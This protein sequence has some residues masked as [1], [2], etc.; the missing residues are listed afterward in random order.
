[1]SSL[2][3][4]TALSGRSRSLADEIAKG[5][6]YFSIALGIAELAAPR[7]ICR[8][9][10]IDSDHERLVRAYGAREIATGIAIL[11]SHDPTPWVWGRATGDAL[12]IGTVALAPSDQVVGKNRKAWSLAALL[13][14]AALDAFCASRLKSEKGNR[15]SARADYSN[16]SG[17]PKG[18][19]VARGAALGF[20]VPR[21][22]RGPEALRAQSVPA[23]PF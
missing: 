23:K 22:M 9:A 15:D 7:A 21:D 8:A 10:G 13:G 6:G 16:R 14:V 3:P 4:P 1:M 12:D 5:L 20:E 11:R 17:F 18:L 19:Q 2:A